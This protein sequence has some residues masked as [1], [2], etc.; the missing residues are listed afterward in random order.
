MA[1]AALLKWAGL[2][3]RRVQLYFMQVRTFFFAAAAHSVVPIV[4]T[5]AAAAPPP[6]ARPNGQ[7][8]RF[9]R[10]TGGGSDACH[11]TR[12]ERTPP[13][14]SPP[15]PGPPLS[16]SPTSTAATGGRRPLPP[17]F[18]PSRSCRRGAP[19]VSVALV[20]AAAP[21]ATG[22]GARVAH[23]PNASG[24]ASM[25]RRGRPPPLRWWGGEGGGPAS[26]QTLPL[27]SA[28]LPSAGG[29]RRVWGGAGPADSMQG[30]VEGWVAGGAVGGAVGGGRA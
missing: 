26:R 17:V 4:G 14:S 22:E 2:D 29:T 10:S 1:E 3:G 8:R 16:A 7:W 5:I 27:P 11:D 15:S 28:R 19:A 30:G 9:C 24:S 25:P 23:L 20:A 12:E 21:V 6:P 18:P 13:T